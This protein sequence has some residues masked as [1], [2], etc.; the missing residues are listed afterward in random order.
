MTVT[1][2]LYLICTV[3]IFISL[4]RKKEITLLCAASIIIVSFSY[5]RSGI[6]SVN[7]VCSTLI[8]GFTDLLSVFVG[9][10]MIISMTYALKESGGNKLL[11][12]KMSFLPKNRYVS[13]LLTGAFMFIISM[14][15][16]PSPAV[17]L[18]GSL[19][20]PV[21][22]EI[23]LPIILLASSVNIFGHGI[24]LSGDFFIQGVPAITAESAG[25]ESSDLYPYL[26]P[27]WAVMTIVVIG[28]SLIMIKC[29]KGEY[30]CRYVRI[31]N[32]YEKNSLNDP[33]KAKL[34]LIACVC[35]LIAAVTVIF[36]FGLSG[37][38]ATYFVAGTA[39]IITGVLSLINFKPSNAAEKAV[40][41]ITDG[42]LTTMKIFAPALLI[43]AFFSLGNQETAASAFGDDAPG[44]LSDI[45]SAVTRSSNVHEAALA[46]LITLISAVYSID[47][48]G[49]AGL[50]VIGSIADS[51]TDSPEHLRIL[52][53]LGQIC[54]IWIGGGT[55][56]PWAVIPVSSVMGVSPVDLVKQNLIPVLCGIIA[57]TAASSIILI[58]V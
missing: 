11:T 42:F 6:L 57:V 43:I 4:I 46:P 36:I 22:D 15:I 14:Y 17:V 19:L 10:A 9:I 7:A 53:S 49:F 54:I 44:L 29:H 58:A 25:L 13:F 26:V 45:V 50:M 18:I 37:D 20:I 39:L 1:H 40:N 51:L 21:A 34:S 56:I 38:D 55:L 27:L 28:V 31:S 30:N 52:T 8:S 48:S 35:L 16:W 5:T 2:V 24:A 12:R 23:G 33:K 41:Y 47:G 3:L 32:K